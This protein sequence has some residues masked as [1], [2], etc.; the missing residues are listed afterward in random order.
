MDSAT[1]M[2]TYIAT[3]VHKIILCYA[4][5]AILSMTLCVCEIR[6][7]HRNNNNTGTC[8]TTND[9]AYYCGVKCY[10]WL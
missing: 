9:V 8:T 4:I 10:H 3:G 5:I 7:Q 6:S 1:N 2:Q